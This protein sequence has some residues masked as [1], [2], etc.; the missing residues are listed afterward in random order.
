MDSDMFE[1][2]VLQKS[3][4][5]VFVDFMQSTCH[6]GIP[7]FNV[8]RFFVSFLYRFWRSGELD[9]VD[10]LC[11]FCLSEGTFNISDKNTK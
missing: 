5:I 4:I 3:F 10:F 8:L 9:G 7:L 2:N 6:A 1:V 11:A